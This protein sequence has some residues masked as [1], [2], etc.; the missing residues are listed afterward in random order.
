MEFEIKR[1]Y[2]WSVLKIV[3]VFYLCI[4][5]LFGMLLAFISNMITAVMMSFNSWAS[6]VFAPSAFSIF[7]NIISFALFFAIA[8]SVVTIIFIGIYNL[9]SVLVG[10]IKIDLD[11]FS[12]TKALHREDNQVIL[13]DK[14]IDEKY[15]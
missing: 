12:D 11:T 7:L 8:G 3:F 10:G 14:P 6:N 1:I 13:R 5:T 15:E 2:A 4:G 9:L